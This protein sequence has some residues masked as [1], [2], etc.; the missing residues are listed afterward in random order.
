LVSTKVKYLKKCQASPD[1]NRENKGEAKRKHLSLHFNNNM[2]SKGFYCSLTALFVFC[3]ISLFFGGCAQVGVPTGGPRDS[4]PPVLVSAVPALYQT[5][6]TADKIVFTFN[7]YVNVEDIQKNLLVSPYPKVNP[8]VSS[9]LRT[10][11][12]KLKDTLLANTTYAI[13]FG[14]AIKDINEGNP[15]KNFTYVFSTG[16]TVDSL[17]FSGQIILAENGKKD[18]TMV[19]LLYR[20]ADD[21]TVQHRKPNYIARCDSAGKFTFTN[22]S[23]GNYKVYGLKDNDGGKTYNSKTEVFAFLDHEII[24]SDSTSPV[25]LYAYMEE[26]DKKKGAVTKSLPEK[27]L[28]YITPVSS[29]EQSLLDSLVINFNRP[30]KTFDPQKIILT[31]SNLNK[32]QTSINLDSTKKILSIKAAW[33]EDNG[34]RLILDKAAVA[35]TLGDQLTKSDTIKFKSKKIADYG[36]IL[37]RFTNMDL[38]KHPVLQFVK[39]EEMFKSIPITGSTWSD[40]MFEPGEYELRILFDD[41]NNGKWD[42]GNYKLKLQPE[43]AITID[44]KLSIRANWDNE[45]D[46]KL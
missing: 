16:N 39:G 40:K 8:L 42:P 11:T 10:V 21:T 3:I 12:V 22:L 32:I 41:N 43:Q 27:K 28:R 45:R 37:I 31:D 17:T 24:V 9:K 6:F 1:I 36:S 30:I 19:A 46:V 15:Y 33:A 13:N 34:Y 35:D 14:N 4:L 20:N 29:A 2:V 7:E 25:T 18:S 38:K 26:K 23:G 44:R 5:N